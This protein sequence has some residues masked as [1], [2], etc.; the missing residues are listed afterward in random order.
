MSVAGA[1]HSPQTSQHIHNRALQP[2]KMPFDLIVRGNELI[3]PCRGSTDQ[4]CPT[5]S[6]PPPTCPADRQVCGGKVQHL[7]GLRGRLLRLGAGAHRGCTFG[8][9]TRLVSR[10][11]AGPFQRLADEVIV[12]ATLQGAP[13]NEADHCGDPP[14]LLAAGNGWLGRRGCSAGGRISVG[15]QGACITTPTQPRRPPLRVRTADRGRRRRRSAQCGT[16]QF[17]EGWP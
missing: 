9:G 1:S 3:W 15:L 12:H 13:L 10:V 6:L 8:E 5:R 7:E 11:W 2:P 4:P 16:F 14:L 17:G